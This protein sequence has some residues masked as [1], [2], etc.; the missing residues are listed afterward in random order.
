MRLLTWNINGVRTLPQYHPWNTLKT[1]D[2]ILNHL[3]ADIIC[4]QEMKSSRQG[5]PKAVAIPPSFE[6]FFSF[7]VKKSGYSGVATYIR[8]NTA[9]PIKAEEGL[10]GIIQ[11][12]P[13]FRAD[14]RISDSDLYP[15]EFPDDTEEV[16]YTDLDSEGRAIVI[17]L[18]LFVL[19][20]LYCP[21]DGTGTEERDRFKMQYH[22]LVE[23]RARDLISEGRHVIIVGD[24]NACASVEDHCEGRLMVERGLAEGLEGEEG[25]WGKDSRRWMRDVLVQEDGQGSGCMVDIVRKF[26]PDRKGMYTCWNTKISARASNYGTRID[27]ILVTPGLV[28]WIKSADIQPHIKGSDHCPVFVDF[29]DEILSSEGSSIQL[30]D[31]LGAQVPA[32]TPLP[33][34]PRIAAKHWDEHKQ[35]LLSTFFVKK[36]DGA[37]D[38]PPT[39]LAAPPSSSAPSQCHSVPLTQSSPPETVVDPTEPPASQKSEPI[40]S[41]LALTKRKSPPDSPP[42]VPVP[43]KKVKGRVSVKPTKTK[44]ASQSTIATFFSQPKASSSTKPTST[45]PSPKKPTVRLKS[46]NAVPLI[47][48]DNLSSPISVP[49]E[50]ADYQFALS[51]SQLE[52]NQQSMS[53]QS[54]TK[55][56]GE[57]KQAWTTLLA[58]TQI[59]KCTAH[60]EPAKEYTVN[61][62]GPNKGKK[63]FICSRPVGPGYDKGRSE[64]PREQVDP[65]YHCS[66]FKWSSDARKEMAKKET[67]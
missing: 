3:E 8:R 26:W 36:A 56:K 12:R 16:D 50:D 37:Q 64:R 4:F 39:L 55:D 51:L 40:A 52:G 59:P 67:S 54:T 5:L 63:F 38:L 45:P 47:E 25:F 31:L 9:L 13:P 44:A 27:F 20:N 61:K 42:S 6:S 66:F 41:S 58:P 33:E 28:P 14:E 23:K 57:S 18:G 43:T 15:P 22:R 24:L 30:R 7:P 1:F 21:N 35:K 2:D 17:D 32:G 11:P 60:G 48:V 10:T 34:P 62:P 29:H 19:I 65:Q 46:S 53:S 49:D